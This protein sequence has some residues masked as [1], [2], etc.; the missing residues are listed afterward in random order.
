MILLLIPTQASELSHTPLEEVKEPTIEEIIET[1]LGSEFVEIAKC[2]S[3]LRQYNE[4]G[5]VL[6]SKTSDKGIMQIN[7]VHWESAESLGIDLDTL[8]G[9]IEYAKLL[10]EKNGTGDWYMSQHCWSHLTLK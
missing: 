10:K 7:Q 3:S 8:E 5:T 2:E 6:I 9:N 4:D 1:E